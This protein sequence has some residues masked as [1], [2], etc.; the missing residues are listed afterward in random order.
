VRP[1]LLCGDFNT[2]RRELPDGQVITFGQT[3][4][5][6]M[7]RSRGPRWDAAERGIIT[8]LRDVRM[9]DVY[10]ELHGYEPQP[11]SWV[12]KRLNQTF[13][14]RFDHV[15]ADPS[16]HPQAFTYRHDLRQ[17][18]ASDHSPVVVRFDG[19]T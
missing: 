4:T 11:A 18:G 17:S 16:L 9:P 13:E 19:P 15:F 6:R 1:R 5:G 14:R 10:R 3:E 12:L 2:P 8:G 7:T